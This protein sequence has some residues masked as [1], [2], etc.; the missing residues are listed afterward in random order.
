MLDGFL[1]A[2]L[3]DA[4][5]QNPDLIQ[6][7]GFHHIAGLAILMVVPLQSHYVHRIANVQPILLLS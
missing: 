7:P 4:Q 5:K 3:N 1:M 6:G 2:Q